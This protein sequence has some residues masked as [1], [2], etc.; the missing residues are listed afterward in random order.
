MFVYI[1]KSICICNCQCQRSADASD[2]CC[3]FGLDNQKQAVMPM[4]A[5]IRQLQQ[6]FTHCLLWYSN[7]HCSP[8]WS[9]RFP[10]S[11]RL[12]VGRAAISSS[13]SFVRFCVYNHLL[14]LYFCL[15]PV[16]APAHFHSSSIYMIACVTAQ[17]YC[18]PCPRRP[19]TAHPRT[20]HHGSAHSPSVIRPKID[21]ETLSNQS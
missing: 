16:P 15:W 6:R 19:R 12:F 14:F 10:L 9:R 11:S 5:S 3:A 17:L 4:M 18:A 20:H 8:D 7:L 2:G 1:H 13:P 21:I